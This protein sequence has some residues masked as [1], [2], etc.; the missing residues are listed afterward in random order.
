MK[1]N[2]GIIGDAHAGPG[3]RQVSLLSLESVEKMKKLGA[4]V[5]P[6]SFAENITTK[7]FPIEELRVGD[8]I[9]I[10]EG[11]LEIT[12]IGKEC[13]NRCAIYKLVGDCVMPREGIFGIVLKGGRVKVGDEIVL[14]TGDNNT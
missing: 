5:K 11:L 2:W 14:L 4:N 10:G 1:E 3:H 7:N 6:G 12:Q 13:H 9:K 8:W